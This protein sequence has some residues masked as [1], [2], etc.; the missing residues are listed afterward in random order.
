MLPAAVFGAVVMLVF[1]AERHQVT[2]TAGT[3]AQ[4]SLPTTSRT[5]VSA[6]PG[7]TVSPAPTPDPVPA[8]DDTVALRVR[9]AVQAKIASAAVGVEVYDRQTG[10]VL[11][12]VDAE[13]QF[14]SMSVVK[15]LIALDVLR[16]GGTGR[17]SLSRMIS[18]SDDTI[19]SSLWVQ[20]GGTSIV[21]RMADLIGLTGTEPP[22]SAG[23]WGSTKLTAADV[24]RIY[25][26]IEDDLPDDD[27]KLLYDA[28]YHAT[29]SGADGTNQYFGIPDAL[30]RTTWAIKQGWGTSGSQAVYNTTG[31]IGDDARYVVVVLTSAPSRYYRTMPVAL[32][33]G[34]RALSELVTG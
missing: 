8:E 24:V 30:P 14:S 32:T 21:T 23:Q 5:S 26:Y 11:T 6:T 34:T 27:R 28:M 20:Q 31:L 13:R 25:N 4:V 1:T 33:T 12:Q 2:P 3:V 9:E 29:E 17:S 18:T 10:V 7:D 16:S 15:L 19:A 22:S